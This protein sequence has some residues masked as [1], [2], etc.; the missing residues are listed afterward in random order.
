M[1]KLN[2]IKIELEGIAHVLQDNLLAVPMYQRSYAWEQT[3]VVDLMQDVATALTNKEKEYFLGSV[4]VTESSERL[5]VVDG[6]QRLATT[7]I[8]LAA[9]RDYFV[10]QEDEERASNLEHDF[11]FRK[12]LRTKEFLPHL[13]LNDGDNDYFLKRVLCRIN[14]PSRKSIKATKLSHERIDNAASLAKAHIDRLANIDKRPVDRLVDLVEYLKNAVQVILIRVHDDA[15]AFVIFETLND[16]GLVLAI[17]DLLKN[18]LFLTA[19]D[20]ISE[21]QQQWVTMISTLEATGEDSIVVDYIR[22]Y[23]SSKHGYTREKE[24][25]SEIKAHVTSKQEAVDF[26]NEIADDARLYAAMLNPEHELWTNYTPNSKSYM[27]TILSLQMV[28]IRP[29]LLAVLREFKGPEVEKALRLMLA[30]IARFLVVG[31]L[32][33]GTLERHYSDRAKEVRS[34]SITT[35][36]Q[37]ATSM[38]EVVPTD[39]VFETAFA[40]ASISKATLARYYLR[41]LEQKNA[42]AREPELI[43]NPN[44]QEVN[45]EHVLPQTFSP[46]W[47]DVGVEVAKVYHKRIGNLALMQASANSRAGN[48][49]FSDK[50]TRYATSSFKLTSEIANEKKWG[51]EEIDARQLRLANLAV[52]TWSIRPT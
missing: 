28:Q 25:Y 49:S 19:Q 35:A 1:S 18:Y 27:A 37:L 12:E 41:A 7:A 23:W 6:Q 14:D 36:K 38:T 3:H 16:R 33:G 47:S 4:V 17:S 26:T 52:K 31:G 15:N 9:I 11:L 29:L 44:E 48:A 22:H 42:G 50:S 43:P 32:G 40:T 30:W 46:D 24:L 20:R 13:M 51:T 45:L 34:G 8:L 10:S 2:Q 5:Q 39:A 21:V